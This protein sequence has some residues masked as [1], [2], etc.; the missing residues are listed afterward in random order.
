[1]NTFKTFVKTAW[2]RL[3]SSKVAWLSLPLAAAQVW[4]AISGEDV[5]R[6]VEI[7]FGAAWSVMAVFLAVNNPA[8]KENF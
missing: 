4:L 7:I 6:Q 1:M 2:A 8:D 3:T 5:S